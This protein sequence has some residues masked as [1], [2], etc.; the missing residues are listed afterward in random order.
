M[1]EASPLLRCPECG[2]TEI[3]RNGNR[4]LSSGEARQR[5]KCKKCT[6]R[7]SEK[8]FSDNAFKECQT[9]N[10]NRQVC[11]VLE[12]AKNL[13]SSTE[14]KT[15]GE[16]GSQRD[17]KVKILQYAAYL[18]NKG[19]TKETIRTYIGALFTLL[20]KGAD[21]F[22]PSSVE[23]VIAKQQKWTLRAKRN[24][25]DWYAHF[26]K[27]LK[28]DWEKPKYKAAD[29]IP[30]FP[31]ESEIDQLIIGSP[32]KVSI[33]LQ[34][35]KETAARIGEIVRLK[36]TD[37]DFQNSTIS[38]NEPEK[39]SNTGVYKVSAE[40]MARIQSLP[41]TS[42]SVLGN[43]ST[44]SLVNMLTTAKRKLA[45]NLCNPRL[46]EIHFHTLRHWKLTMYAHAVKDPFLVQL[47]ARHKD[48]KCT[49]RYIHYSKIVFGK[50]SNSDE[51]IVK[52]AKTVD[53]AIELMK[54][55]FEYHVEF[56]GVKL[57]RK[58]K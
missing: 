14:T 6:Y 28:L 24:Y 29:K 45:A 5:W 12:E 13:S 25:V 1:V 41:R 40:L 43:T 2:S 39:G 44:K 8:R 11:A 10:V 31:L 26:A 27:F 7:F 56:D 19:R 57:F 48:I 34:I 17:I 23:E 46:A 38:I 30:F 47:F 35:A 54:V 9:E 50:D 33:A 49:S 37:I 51:W 36:W 4:Y 42:E 22:N 32:R 16:I 52:A 15:V 53:E 18:E 58:R 21:I 20:K 55:G 3:T